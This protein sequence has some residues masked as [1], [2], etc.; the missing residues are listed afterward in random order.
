MIPWF[1]SEICVAGCEVSTHRG[2]SE[3]VEGF[4]GRIFKLV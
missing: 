2:H 3:F 4:V 1:V